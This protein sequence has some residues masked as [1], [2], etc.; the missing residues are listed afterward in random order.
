[1]E[2]GTDPKRS[3]PR[4]NRAVVVLGARVQAD[5]S[6]SPLL[7]RRI[8][9]GVALIATDPE[10]ETVM[11]LS[12]GYGKGCGPP[13][14]TEAEVMAAAARRCG[15]S[16]KVPIWLEDR[17]RNTLEN[18]RASSDLLAP[19]RPGRVVVVTDRAHLP[20]ALMCFRAARTLHDGRWTIT[21]HAV[22]SPDRAEAMRTWGREAV[23]T[24]LYRIRLL[25][26]AMLAAVPPAAHDADAHRSPPDG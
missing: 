1:M 7:M 2:R 4:I 21:G 9:A 6:P 11:V 13:L 10:P 22:S 5:G 15:L 19:R 18:A 26:G 17:S 16:A 25:R 14:P 23:A 24:V 3:Q 12:G 8:R 20:R